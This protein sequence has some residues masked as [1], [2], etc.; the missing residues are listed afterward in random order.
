MDLKVIS[1]MKPRALAVLDWTR[2]KTERVVKGGPCLFCK[3]TGLNLVIFDQNEGKFREKKIF[4]KN[5][6]SIC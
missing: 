2:G 4:Q 6:K 1:E 3:E 5:V